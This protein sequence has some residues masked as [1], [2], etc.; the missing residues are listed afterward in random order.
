MHQDLVKDITEWALLET[1]ILV[2]VEL[3]LLK[4]E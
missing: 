3:F 4:T 1:D 2:L